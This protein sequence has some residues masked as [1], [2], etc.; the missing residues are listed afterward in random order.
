M[1]RRSLRLLA[2][3]AFVLV[4]PFFLRRRPRVE[5]KITIVSDPPA[6]EEVMF[7]PQGA[8]DGLKRGSLF[9]DSSTISPELARREAVR[10]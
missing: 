3:V 1:K 4:F 6:L 9:I 5:R 7:G 2:L 10:G 8:L